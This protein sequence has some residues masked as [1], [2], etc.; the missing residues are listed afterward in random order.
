MKSH[1][2]SAKTVDEATELA[3]AEF[4]VSLEDLEIK[5][6][7]S[8]RSGILGMGGEMAVI[9][10]KNLIAGADQEEDGAVVN[11]NA[12]AE[13]AME[14]EH[15][16]PQEYV[17]DEEVEKLAGEILTYL[18]GC[19]NV[20]AEVYVRQELENGYHIFEIE[21]EGAGALIGV[22]GNTMQDLQHLVRTLVSG[23]LE[24]PSRIILDIDGY[25]SRR[26]EQLRK[27][28]KR[29][30]QQVSRFG[31]P[32]DLAPMSPADRRIIH[33]ALSNQNNI[34]TESYGEGRER[35]VVVKP[36]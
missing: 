34:K 24:R 26:H 4:G 10:V 35:R 3:L 7:S 22:H 14:E 16:P 21:G 32:V 12:G 19:V 1:R 15:E 13:P 20:K 31:K 6:V 17:K 5:V 18:I 8:G 27:M 29:T 36:S 9:E 23:M 25:R 28:A 33:M 30:A 2:F 11:T